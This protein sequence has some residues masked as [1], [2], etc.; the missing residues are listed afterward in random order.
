MLSTLK[1]L[2]PINQAPIH[3][4]ATLI[5]SDIRPSEKLQKFNKKS[6]DGVFP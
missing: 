4:A 1:Q 2:L 5:S 6:Y 3:D